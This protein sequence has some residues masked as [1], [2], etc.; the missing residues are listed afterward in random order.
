MKTGEVLK[1]LRISRSTLYRWV[2]AGLIRRKK[3][4]MR[5]DYSDEDVYKLFTKDM[6]RKTYIY[7]RV[8]TTKQK[9]DL[10]NQINMLTSWCFTNGYQLHGV[11]AEIARSNL[12]HMA[13]IS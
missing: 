3:I 2:S 12:N 9:N 6:P 5:Y 10:Q 11:F 13:Q 7:A 8:S 1:L 4:G